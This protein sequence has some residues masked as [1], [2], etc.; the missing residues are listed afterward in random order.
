VDYSYAK[1]GR[2]QKN[3]KIKYKQTNNNKPALKFN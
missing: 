1:A 3:A 2:P